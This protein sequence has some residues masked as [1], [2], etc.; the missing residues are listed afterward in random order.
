[1]RAIIGMAD[2]LVGLMVP[3]TTAGACPCG[4][5]VTVGTCG[6]HGC[7]T[8]RVARICY[9]CDCQVRSKSCLAC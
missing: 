9:T 6:T 3:K 4:D 5:C 1:M 7:P 2:R 8:F